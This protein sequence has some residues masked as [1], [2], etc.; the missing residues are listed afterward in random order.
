V[1]GGFARS[2]IRGG[3]SSPVISVPRDAL[4]PADGRHSVYVVEN[5]RAV[6]RLVRVEDPGGVGERVPVL[7]G[8]R[9]GERV[10]VRGAS[11]LVDGAPVTVLR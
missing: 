10:V 6:R 2:E 9:P 3:S 5:G 1:V 11:G 8:L 7:A 4:V